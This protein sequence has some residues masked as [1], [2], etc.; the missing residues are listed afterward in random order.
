MTGF[1]TGHAA[2]GTSRVVVEIR[3]VNHR[4]F[5]AR[6]R[7]SGPLADLTGLVEDLLRRSLGRGRVDA[8]LRLERTDGNLLDRARVVALAR[9]L[10]AIRD[11]VDA[12]GPLPWELLASMSGALSQADVDPEV[13]RAAVERA[14]RDA[15]T[16]LDSLRAREGA[17]LRIELA[18]WLDSASATLDA[19]EAA[20]PAVVQRHHTKLTERVAVLLGGDA[21]AV[22]G[23]RVAHEL[24][25]LADKMD[26]TEELAR[27]RAHLALFRS[28]LDADESVGRKLD[29]VS[30]ELLREAN[31]IGSKNA[32][33]AIAHRVIDL[34]ADIERLREQ[35]QNV[36]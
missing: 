35:V 3:S 23:A 33:A 36:L 9:E 13:L 18:R 2:S 4:F 15:A 21:G 32:D 6:I 11:E 24:A 10:G 31:T 19:I 14:T 29:F 1:G 30:Q 7:G 25:I 16:E 26:V 17:S 8:T 34:K 20:M 22:D 28:L 27:A 12:G 5:D